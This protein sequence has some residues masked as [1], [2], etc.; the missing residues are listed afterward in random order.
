M[1]NQTPEGKRR[2]QRRSQRKNRP[3]VVKWGGGEGEIELASKLMYYCS[4]ARA[5]DQTL[6]DVTISLKE[7][8]KHTYYLRST[9]P[10]G[11]HIFAIRSHVIKV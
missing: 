3:R 6:Q 5:F 2:I 4:R 8:L 7:R 11:T 1:F 9:L 10:P